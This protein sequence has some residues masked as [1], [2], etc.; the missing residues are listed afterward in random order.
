MKKAISLLALV[1]TL[2]PLAY[3]QTD[4]WRFRAGL[5]NSSGSQRLSAMQLQSVLDSLRHKTGFPGMRFD[6]EGFLT[7]GDRTRIGGGSATARELLIAAVEG[8]K[9]F[10]LESH[11][12]SPA[13]AFARMGGGPVY[14]NFTTNARIT[15]ESLQLDFADF[16]QLHGSREALAAFDLGFALLHELA[17]GVYRLRDAKDP[18]RLGECERHINRMRRELGLPERQQ[19]SARARK[20]APSESTIRIE[21]AELLF[22]CVSQTPGRA[23]T[24]RYFYLKW[25]AKRVASTAEAAWRR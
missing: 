8:D 4:K 7:L 21:L 16:A 2:A 24:K 22:V 3:A 18:G 25:D 9:A 20:L 15:V 5:R 11:D 23:G 14:N 6:E 13:I 1:C 10:E 12:H 17:H 19:Y